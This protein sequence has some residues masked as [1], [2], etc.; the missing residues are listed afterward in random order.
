MR[1]QNTIY[2][3]TP[4]AA[5]YIAAILSDSRTTEV[6]TYAL[7]QRHRREPQQLPLRAALLDWLHLL[8]L[9]TNDEC[10]EIT[11][12][13]GFENPHMERVRAMRPV[14]FRAVAVFL[15]DEDSDV[16]HAALAAAIPLAED[17]TLED[18][19][20]EL[21]PLA[22]KLLATST[23]HRHRTCVIDGLR[24]WGHDVQDLAPGALRARPVLCSSD[25]PLE[26]SVTQMHDCRMEVGRVPEL[27]ERVKRE[28]DAEAWDELDHRLVLEQD[29]VFPASFAS[30]PCLVRLA[31]RSSRAR[32]LAGS[33]IRRAAG[34]H[35]CDHLL[36]N[37]ASAITEFRAL[38]D[39]HLRSRPIDYLETFLALLAVAEQYH[40]AA[41]LGDFTDDFYH[42]PC[43][44]CAVDMTIAIG[45]HGRYS[46]I[47]DWNLGDIDQRDLR[48]AAP[49]ELSGTGRW[50]YETVVRDGQGT[51]AD[52]ITY[53]F[54]KAECPRCASV[55]DIADE[56][57]SANLPVLR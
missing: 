44:H 24:A 45:D 43:P 20:V 21:V 3:A 42:L 40:W 38:L 19:R 7:Q 12:R 4:P 56:Y 35:G 30:L 46:A 51:L 25:G 41:V 9:D 14:L 6:G 23:D 15:H 50:M 26:V 54:G 47:R 53:L 48:R 52:G 10:L 55:F 36:A 22:H 39:R 31:A 17:P 57:T 49:D 16:R 13:Y 2:P 27:L 18:V 28:D 37:C 1:H 34:H 5:L 8:A 29:L 11:R 32:G 33:I